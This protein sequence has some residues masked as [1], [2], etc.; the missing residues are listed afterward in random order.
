MVRKTL[1]VLLS[2]D[3]EGRTYVPTG[4]RPSGWSVRSLRSLWVYYNQGFLRDGPWNV[5]IVSGDGSGVNRRSRSGIG[6]GRSGRPGTPGA[7]RANQQALGQTP[8]LIF[9]S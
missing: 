1:R 9:R 2:E 4:L 3:T 7:L 5:L 6:R 8:N